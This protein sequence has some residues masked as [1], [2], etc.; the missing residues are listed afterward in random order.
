MASYF[1]MAAS[2][3]HGFFDFTAPRRA[4]VQS[5][6]LT[7]LNAWLAT[8]FRKQHFTALAAKDYV[9]MAVN[10]GAAAQDGTLVH[11]TNITDFRALF[12]LV[13][14]FLGIAAQTAQRDFKL[15]LM[16]VW[17]AY[18]LLLAADKHKRQCYQ[19]R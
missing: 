2:I 7:E 13:P 6:F 11:I 15:C 9:A 16:R 8:L 3:I 4:L 12:A 5:T 10:R 17:D 14:V 1:G 19:S 18:L